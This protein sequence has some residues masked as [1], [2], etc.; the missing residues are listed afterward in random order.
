[1][2]APW[3]RG[4]HAWVLLTDG[5]SKCLVA[6]AASWRRVVRGSG[7]TGE[8]ATPV[9]QYLLCRHACEAGAP[10][11]EWTTQTESRSAGAV[12]AYME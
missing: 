1:M 9:V 2:H 12:R 11:R 3:H 5:T 10:C 7:C 6:A 8:L 4:L